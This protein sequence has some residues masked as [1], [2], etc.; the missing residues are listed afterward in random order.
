VQWSSAGALAPWPDEAP[1]RGSCVLW[2]AWCQLCPGALFV[3]ADFSSFC[4]GQAPPADKKGTGEVVDVKAQLMFSWPRAH[5]CMW[6]T[7]A[8]VALCFL[9]SWDDCS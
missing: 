7:W 8:P 5:S 4:V 3:T 2:P 6:R 9:G 1:A